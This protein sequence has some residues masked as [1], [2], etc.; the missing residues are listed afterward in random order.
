MNIPHAFTTRLGGV[1]EGV[2]ASLNIAMHRGDTDEN[3]ER[4][5]EIL[6]DALGF[7]LESLVLTRQT[8]SDIVRVVTKNDARGIDH[9]NYP[10]SDALITNDAGCALAVFT[11]DCTPI[12]LFDQVTGAVGAVHAG[13]RG[14]AADIA[15]KTVC[16]MVAELGCHPEN[17]RAAIGPNIGYCC[18]ETDR[19]VPEAIIEAFGNEAEQF[20]RKEGEKYRV[21][22]KAVNAL[23]LRRAGVEN[24]EISDE[25][26]M[27]R[28][29]RFWSHRITGA[30]R[31]SQGA[32]IICK[33]VKTNE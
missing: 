4:N 12:L 29:D 2:F 26:T 22:L 21:D 8:H 1:S 14:T 5:Y 28:P 3:V 13:W 32:L 19:D 16:A 23:A 17:I 10:E 7:D 27:C 11:A 30:S 15:G 24:I 33:G 25:C 20:I 9:R 6:A 18:F 31:G